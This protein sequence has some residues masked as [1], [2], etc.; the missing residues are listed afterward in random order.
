[1]FYGLHSPTT[2]ANHVHNPC[3]PT[4]FVTHIHDPYLSSLWLFG[5]VF[6]NGLIFFKLF[7]YS[8]S[9]GLITTPHVLY[10]HMTYVYSFFSCLSHTITW[11]R[12]VIIVLWSFWLRSSILWMHPHPHSPLFPPQPHHPYTPHLCQHT[13]APPG[14]GHHLVT[15]YGH[16]EAPDYTED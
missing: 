16:P 14:E 3:Q 6:W 15:R 2:S 13:T 12:E 10:V 5:N 7:L 11:P 4:M 1:M 9:L 8:F